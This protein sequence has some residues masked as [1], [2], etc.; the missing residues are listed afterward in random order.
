M[1]FCYYIQSIWPFISAGGFSRENAVPRKIFSASPKNT[2]RSIFCG[3]RCAGNKLS[4]SIVETKKHTSQDR[5]C[6]LA[7]ACRLVCGT[8]KIPAI[9]ASIRASTKEKAPHANCVSRLSTGFMATKRCPLKREGTGKKNCARNANCVQAQPG[10]RVRQEESPAIFG[11]NL[12][13]RI[14]MMLVNFSYN[15]LA[16]KIID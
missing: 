2:A 3:A 4:S 16:L 11:V 6:F 14:E 1:F 12:N 5:V 7:A 15:F 13:P 8:K 9:S 10:V